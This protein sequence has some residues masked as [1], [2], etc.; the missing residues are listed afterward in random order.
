MN[1]TNNTICQLITEQLPD[2]KGI[3]LFGSHADGSANKDSDFDIA[4][5]A[6][7]KL[8]KNRLF[9]ISQKLAKALKTDVDL[10]DLQSASTVLR[11][12]IIQKMIRLY[13]SDE[14]LCDSFEALIYSMYIKFNEERQSILDKIKTTGR[15]YNERRSN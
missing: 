12:Q 4:L 14:T 1:N 15:V 5:L 13:C 7:K 3:Y 11:M 9:E 2:I 8:H 10:I 6:D